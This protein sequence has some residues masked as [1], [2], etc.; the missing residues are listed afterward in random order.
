MGRLEI[1]SSG[2]SRALIAQWT[3]VGPLVPTDQAQASCE[4]LRSKTG[5]PLLSREKPVPRGSLFTSRDQRSDDDTEDDVAVR[6]LDLAAENE[7]SSDTH[8]GPEG[9]IPFKR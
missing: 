5:H 6:S 8:D 3:Y 1:S 9:S 2:I 4:M 7:R